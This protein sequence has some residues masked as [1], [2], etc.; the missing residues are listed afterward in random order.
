MVNCMQG[1]C[2]AGVPDDTV[3]INSGMNVIG[4]LLSLIF[5]GWLRIA[6]AVAAAAVSAA[7][8]AEATVIAVA[9]EKVNLL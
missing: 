9:N 1:M 2:Y 7:E 5:R 4:C 8:T 3:N 6:F